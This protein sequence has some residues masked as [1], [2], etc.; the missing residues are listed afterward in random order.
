MS[1]CFGFC[2]GSPDQLVSLVP[3]MTVD[4]T[5]KCS[6][7]PPVGVRRDDVFHTTRWTQVRSAKM[8]SP[9][10]RRALSELCVAYYEPV[11][12]FL[13]YELRDR[14]GDSAREFAHDFFAQVLAGNCIFNAIKERG[15][16]RSYLLGSVK[17]YLSHRREAASRLK[18]GG[19]AEMLPLDD[20]EMSLA[21]VIPDNTTLSPDAN[22]DRQWAL[23][24]V[25]RALAALRRECAEEGRTAFFEQVK[26]WLVG[27]AS[28]GDQAAAAVA[29]GMN[30]NAFKVAV[31][32]LKRRYR[33]LIREEVAGTLEDPA[34]I[35]SEMQALFAALEKM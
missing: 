22:F 24:V 1:G 35:D 7:E 21:D 3:R 32:R 20:D 28:H 19:G 31:H 23:T 13:R 4:T 27:D 33:D 25:A 30:A 17:H 29:C 2:C 26:P 14:N 6:S 11:T 9:E 5:G 12:T 10:G 34:L 15:R 16:F 8:A 18:R